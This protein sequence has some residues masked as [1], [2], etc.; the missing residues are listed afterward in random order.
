M[1][2]ADA[3]EVLLSRVTEAIHLGQLASH[4]DAQVSTLDRTLFNGRTCE[5]DNLGAEDEFGRIN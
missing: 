4:F 5:D 1:K 3:D 2:K